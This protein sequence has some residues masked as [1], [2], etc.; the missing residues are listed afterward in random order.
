MG[1]CHIAPPYHH[2]KLYSG[3]VVKQCEGHFKRNQ[4]YG[5]QEG[6]WRTA[7]FYIR[8]QT[9]ERCQKLP[10]EPYCHC[11]QLAR[12]RLVLIGTILLVILT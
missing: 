11:N 7:L 5:K 10:R 1:F 2:W 9:K 4:K 6:K 12:P 8:P 3:I